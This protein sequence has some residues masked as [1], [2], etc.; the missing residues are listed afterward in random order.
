MEYV[1]DFVI[2]LIWTGVCAVLVY[3][4]ELVLGRL[5]YQRMSV[6]DEQGTRVPP[7]PRG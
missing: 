4:L 2:L 1:Y 7:P 6:A 3:G 5:G